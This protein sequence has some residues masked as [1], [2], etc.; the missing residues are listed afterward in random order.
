MDEITLFTTIA[1]APPGDPEK[2]RQVA[3]TRLT[4]AMNSSTR[5]A[6]PRRRPL[7]LAS[8]AAAAVAVAATGVLLTADHPSAGPTAAPVH[9]NVAAWSVNTNANGTITFVVRKMAESARLEHVLAEAGVPAIVQFGENC[10][11]TGQTLPTHGV[12]SGPKYVGGATGK[13]EQVH[14]KP[15]PDWAY[16]VTPSAMPSGSR[17]VI[18]VGPGPDP[19]SRFNY[20]W[21]GYELVPS[22]IH[23]ACGPH[24]P[25]KVG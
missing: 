2:I 19:G 17:F 18:S 8:A 4:A 22:G 23:V 21:I 13:P 24:V 10:R 20:A 9:V 3:R 1:P 6:R 15:Y 11:A 5:L 25:P 14:G 7:V 16:T 12:I